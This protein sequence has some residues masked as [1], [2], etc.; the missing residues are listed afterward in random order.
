MFH[1]IPNTTTFITLMMQ[2]Y[3]GFSDE[4]HDTLVNT[5]R[6]RKRL[7]GLQADYSS[8]SHPTISPSSEPSLNSSTT[9]PPSPVRSWSVEESKVT[10]IGGN[11]FDGKLT[12][13][14]KIG[15][16]VTPSNVVVEL[17]DHKCV[18]LKDPTSLEV[19]LEFDDY[20]ASPYEYDIV[21]HQDKIGLG[22]GGFVTY[23]GGN[24][25]QGSIEFCTRLSTYEGDIQVRFRETNFILNFDL[26]G[27][28]FVLSNL[29]YDGAEISEFSSNIDYVAGVEACQCD[30][31]YSCYSSD[32]VPS[33]SQNENLVL[34][35]EPT[36]QSAVEISNFN[37]E[38]SAGAFTYNPV[39]FGAYTWEEDNLTDV[40]TLGKIVKISTP[41]VAQFYVQEATSINVL[42]NAH[43]SFINSEEKAQNEASFD[44]IVDLKYEE[45]KVDCFKKIFHKMQIG[46]AHV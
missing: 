23:S 30:H 35:L 17:Y 16:A 34:C 6:A 13:E 43:L 40:S 36:D 33:I 7:R 37:V 39:V 24:Q 38:L 11:A 32:S 45:P 29:K 2:F 27:N 5:G 1:S 19:S 9:P 28:E 4:S 14:N 41:I 21:I 3:L 31:N 20:I 22:A 25:S 8:S 10:F 15:S 42:G 44:M 18:N 46:R 26:T 12:V